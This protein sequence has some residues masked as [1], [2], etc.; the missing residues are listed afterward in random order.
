MST[1]MDVC[2]MQVTWM[3][4]LHYIHVPRFVLFFCYFFLIYI[5]LFFTVIRFNEDIAE[6]RYTKKKKAEK[7]NRKKK[8]KY[9][10]IVLKAIRVEKSDGLISLNQQYKR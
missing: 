6:D 5:F 10:N 8:K 2:S 3:S 7:S 1:K 4:N 9:S